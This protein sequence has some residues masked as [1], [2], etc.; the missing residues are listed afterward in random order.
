MAASKETSFY[1]D[2]VPNAERRGTLSS[3]NLNKNLDAKVSNP[4][5]DI[6]K[7]LLMRD[8]E[9]FATQSGLT[10]IIPGLKKGALIA[11]NPAGCWDQTGS[12]GANLSFPTEFGISVDASVEPGLREHNEWIVGL[13]MPVPTL[14]PP[15]SA[16]NAQIQSITISDVAAQSL[17]LQSFAGMNVLAFILIFHFVPGTKQRT[18]EELDYIFAVPI[19]RFIAHQYRVE[20]PWWFKRWVLFRKDASKKPLYT[21]ESGVTDHSTLRRRSLARAKASE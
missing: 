10:D 4:L 1:H 21:F 2:A 5:A 7:D 9:E 16:A 13:V 18:L 14:D 8:V 12:N 6:P 3:M 11:Q 20:L 15:S 19:R 17:F